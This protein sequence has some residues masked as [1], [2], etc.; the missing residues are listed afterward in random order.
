MMG[1]GEGKKVSTHKAGTLT[2]VN[3]RS[4]GEPLL[5]TPLSPISWGNVTL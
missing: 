3:I 1:T 2:S 4:L 5:T